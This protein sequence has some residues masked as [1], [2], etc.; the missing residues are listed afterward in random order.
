M[1]IDTRQ[2]LATFEI[3]VTLLRFVTAVNDL[4][5]VL[6]GIHSALNLLACS[7]CGNLKV[8]GLTCRENSFALLC[9]M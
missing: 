6:P 3:N 7:H 4:Y 1:Y 8:T 5:K 2:V 9:F